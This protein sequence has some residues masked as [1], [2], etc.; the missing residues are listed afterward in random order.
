MWS[1]GGRSVIGWTEILGDLLLWPVGRSSMFLSEGDPA[2]VVACRWRGRFSVH[3]VRI[4][5]IVEM[6]LG[7]ERARRGLRPPLGDAECGPRDSNDPLSHRQASRRGMDAR[8]SDTTASIGTG[9][10]SNS[11]NTR[12]AHLDRSRRWRAAEPARATPRSPAAPGSH[13]L[14]RAGPDPNAAS[15]AFT[16]AS[17]RDAS[18]VRKRRR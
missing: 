3:A 13:S 7:P 17:A 11:N 8:R 16:R 5:P 4:C 2:L 6:A 1:R 14:C 12:M 18:T 15:L 10:G 9:M